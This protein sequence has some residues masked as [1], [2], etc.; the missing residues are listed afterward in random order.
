MMALR[1][2]VASMLLVIIP[3]TY[4]MPPG[5]HLQVCI[6]EDGY[7]DVMTVGC[8]PVSAPFPPPPDTDHVL[9]RD[10]QSACTDYMFVCKESEVCRPAC[11]FPKR[12]N[13]PWPSASVPPGMDSEGVRFSPKVTRFPI[14]S[15]GTPFNA[16]LALL[17]TVVLLI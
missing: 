11:M 2:I 5:M 12:N 9:A 15:P 14:I 1:N 7:W 17:S 16:H 10:H 8:S 3:M 4:V 13:S 6:D